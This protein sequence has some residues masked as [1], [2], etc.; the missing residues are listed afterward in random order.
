[1]NRD[2]PKNTTADETEVTETEPLL[3]SDTEEVTVSD[4]DTS[5]ET[6]YFVEPA[7]EFS[8]SPAKI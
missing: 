5:P 7:K 3:T 4:I 8:M 1:M 2:F 6:V